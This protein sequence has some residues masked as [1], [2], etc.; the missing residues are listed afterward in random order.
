[1]PRQETISR[2][3]DRSG[4][5]VEHT[6][7]DAVL[8]DALMPALGFGHHEF[9]IHFGDVGILPGIDS[10]A[11]QPFDLVIL[12]LVIGRRETRAGFQHT[13]LGRVFEAFRQ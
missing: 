2:K 5:Y 4:E 6:R 12:T 9:A 7:I 3:T 11:V 1:M 13:H 10:N 8:G